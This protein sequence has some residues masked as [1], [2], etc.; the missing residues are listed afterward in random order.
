MSPCKPLQTR[1]VSQ[2]KDCIYNFGRWRNPINHPAA[3]LRRKIV[4]DNGSYRNCPGFEDHDLWLRL[5]KNG[6]NLYNHNFPLVLARVG[7]DHAKGRH[8]MRYALK[9]MKFLGLCWAEKLMH[10]KFIVI[11]FIVTIPISLIPLSAYSCLSHKLLR[12]SLAEAC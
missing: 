7:V 8:G 12:A 4:F 10:R 5:L 6:T 1:D 9:E 11:L 3:I 2:G